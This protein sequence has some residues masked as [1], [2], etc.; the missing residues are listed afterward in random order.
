MN[1]EATPS[2]GDITICIECANVLIFKENLTV[3]KPIPAEALI[4]YMMPEVL[5]VVEAI[6]AMK[7]GAD[8]G[9]H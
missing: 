5:L 2:E 7:R 4:A 6:K 1:P 9:L 8:E 3:R